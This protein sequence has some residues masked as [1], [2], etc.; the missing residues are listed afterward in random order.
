MISRGQG[1]DSDVNWS[2][3]VSFLRVSEGIRRILGVIRLSGFQGFRT[4]F[5]LS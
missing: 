4:A 2:I 1:K 5:R 3:S